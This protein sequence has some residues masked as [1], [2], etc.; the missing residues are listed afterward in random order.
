MRQ[1]V[2]GVTKKV[3]KY[4]FCGNLL[5]GKQSRYCSPSCYN[6]N[7]K[8]RE[9]EHYLQHHPPPPDRTCINCKEKYTPKTSRQQV[10]GKTCRKEIT[11]QQIAERRSN[12]PVVKMSTYYKKYSPP[13]SRNKKHKV[14]ASVTNISRSNHQ[15]QINNFLK[16]GGK[17]KVLPDQRDGRVPGVGGVNFLRI[18]VDMDRK[19]VADVSGD[20][21]T[22]TLTGF[23][24]ELDI[25]DDKGD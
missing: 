15:E 9:R 8:E 18:D 4:C 5:T 10:C 16:E 3:N 24:Y 7:R 17:V 14:A 6:F 22:S 20:W 11:A 23:G 1:M 25:M 12:T 21:E 19:I 2:N 13:K